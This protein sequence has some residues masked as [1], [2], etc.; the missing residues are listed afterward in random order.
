MKLLTCAGCNNYYIMLKVSVSTVQCVI[1]ILLKL[2]GLNSFSC[3][4][5]NSMVNKFYDFL[6]EIFKM[7]PSKFIFER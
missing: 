7:M 3:H 4:N 5:L 6:K 2:D 1:I